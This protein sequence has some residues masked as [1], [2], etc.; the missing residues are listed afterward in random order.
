M[1]YGV[2]CDTV[3]T[4]MQ[5]PRKYVA[6][7]IMDRISACRTYAGES[8]SDKA[9]LNYYLRSKSGY[10][11]CTVRQKTDG[12]S[13]EDAGGKGERKNSPLYKIQIFERG[14]MNMQFSE[15]M[16][17]FGESIFT[18]LA[19][20]KRGKKEAEE[21]P[22]LISALVRRIYPLHPHIIDAL[23]EAAKD[24]RNYVYAIKDLSEL[25]RA[26]AQWYQR[27]DIR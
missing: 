27:E 15:R 26:V 8:Y 18:T 20:M 1:D 5:M 12:I 21:K 7:M 25:H 11:L 19:K 6:E 9:P 24:K 23:V 17:L 14:E 3:I 22:L 2:D 13:A 4:G 10:G 16:E